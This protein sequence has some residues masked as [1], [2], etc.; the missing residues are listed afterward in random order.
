MLPLRRMAPGLNV[1]HASHPF[2]RIGSIIGFVGGF[3]SAAADFFIFRFSSPNFL[4]RTFEAGGFFFFFYTPFFFYFFF[5]FVFSTLGILHS[6]AI[7]DRILSMCVKV[8]VHPSY[9][10]FLSAEGRIRLRRKMG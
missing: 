5:F 4:N 7:Q 10:P 9:S 2:S 1:C 3:T 8:S 6:N